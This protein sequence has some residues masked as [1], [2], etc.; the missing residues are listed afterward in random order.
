MTNFILS[1]EESTEATIEIVSST[2]FPPV[3]LDLLDYHVWNEI[4]PSE[5]RNQRHSFQSLELLQ[6]R[7]ENMSVSYHKLILHHP[8][9]NRNKLVRVVTREIGSP[10]QYLLR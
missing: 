10:I 4:V 8:S 7:T 2:E 6:Q 1:L 3:D 5:Y 9:S